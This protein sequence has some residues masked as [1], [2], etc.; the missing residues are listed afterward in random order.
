MIAAPARTST[1]PLSTHDWV[2]QARA[3]VV[4]GVWLGALVGGVGGRL[5]MLVLRL[6]SPDSVRGVTSDD[7]FRIGEVTLSGTYGLIALGAGIGVIGAAAY[8]W[9]E[10]WLIGPGW[11]RQL[12]VAL[13]AGAVVGSMLVHTDG[14]DFRLLRPLWLAIGF[15]FLIPALFGFFIGP[16]EHRLA[17]PNAWIDRGRRAWAVP[18]V[19]LVVFLPITI[20]VVV[21]LAV[22]L[23]WSPVK[24]APTFEMIRDARLVGVAVRGAWLTIAVGGLVTLVADARTILA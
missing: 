8:R 17:K 2:R 6:L 4:A 10:H 16:L 13:G 11:F 21:V 20:V 7:G 3:T 23:V 12:T 15:F 1:P 24:Q 22:T 18:L 19:S 9:V 14:V 5:A